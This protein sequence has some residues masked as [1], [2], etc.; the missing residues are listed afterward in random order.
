MSVE[1]L[2]INIIKNKIYIIRDFKVM[3]DS[4]L[5][6]L[7][8]VSTKK[9]NPAVRRN[10]DRFPTDFMFQ[11]S[12]I[13]EESL[14]SQIV[15]SKK[16]R[17]GRRFNRYAFTELGIAMLSS[18]LGSDQAIQMIISIMRVFFELRKVVSQEAK[19]EVKLNKLQESTSELF[20]VVFERLDN[21][22]IKNP[23]LPVKCRKIG[24]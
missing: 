12:D 8:G 17:G 15:T 1:D 16:G 20:Q 5:A 6:E 21:F 7:Y 19:L 3:L 9:L 4:D 24:F 14:R 13:E 22:E 18:V 11:L 23:I 2:P 10:A